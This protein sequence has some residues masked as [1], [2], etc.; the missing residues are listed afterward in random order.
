[1]TN[2]KPYWNPYV[3]G[4]G[5]GLTLLASYVVLG[6]GLGASGALAR[7][8][9][10]AAHEAAP[11]AVL[12]NAYLGPWFEGQNPLRHYLVAMLGGVF[13]GG[14]GSALLARRF[15][16][17]VERGPNASA[18]RRLVFALLGGALVGFASR[19]AGGCTSGLALSGGALLQ[20][21][22]WAFTGAVFASGFLF[23]PLVRKEWS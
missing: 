12:G 19:V 6:T 5:L 20:D 11:A 9:A 1:M 13:V 17:T 15:R 21:G 4:V 14:L 23:A 22:S 3:A 7:G 8:A 10:A 16:A 18:G 2:P